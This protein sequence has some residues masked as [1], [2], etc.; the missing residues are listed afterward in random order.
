MLENLEKLKEGTFGNTES[1]AA[2]NEASIKLADDIQREIDKYYKLRSRSMGGGEQLRRKLENESK[3]HE[4]IMDEN[5][6]DLIEE[7]KKYQEMRKEGV[8]FDAF[9]F[10]E[11]TLVRYTDWIKMHRNGRCNDMYIIDLLREFE[12]VYL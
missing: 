11:D 6:E 1:D 7:L 10:L 9:L 3:Q 5:V 4:K 12:V 8:T 2:S